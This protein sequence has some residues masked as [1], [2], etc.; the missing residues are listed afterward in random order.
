MRACTHQHRQFNM[1]STRLWITV[2]SNRGLRH[3]TALAAGISTKPVGLSTELSTIVEK[4]PDV[5]KAQVTD[6]GPCALD[7]NKAPRSNAI[8]FRDQHDKTCE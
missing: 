3:Q 8:R 7:Y 1:F 2:A 6:L 5:Q 4:A